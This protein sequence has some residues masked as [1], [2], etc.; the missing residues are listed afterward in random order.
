[1]SLRKHIPNFITSLNIACG[2][3]GVVFAFRGRCDLALYLMLAA[4]LFD[5]CDGFAARALGA[6][7]DIGKELDS[8]CDVVS[9]GVLPSIMLYSTSRS[10]M[11]NASWVCWTPLF[12]AVFSA[13]RLA[14]FNVDD[15][16]TD[17]FIGLPTPACALLVGALCY[18]VAYH[19]TSFLAMWMS[20]SVF[21]PIL[22]ASLCFLLVCEIPMFSFKFHKE[23]SRQLKI[24]R[25]AFLAL[26]AVSVVICLIFRLNWSIAL[27][28]SMSCYVAKNLL[29]HI[30]GLN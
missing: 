3:V 27:L 4:G 10:C 18:F 1:M 12:I 6:Y 21:V 16:Q 11:M 14:K 19:S 20:G 15:R 8:L 26:V 22:S 7:S 9:F 13:L 2:I 24:K 29:Y 5:F 30:A 17:G 23:D 28:L 25:I